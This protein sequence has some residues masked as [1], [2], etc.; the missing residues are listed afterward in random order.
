MNTP[1]LEAWAR[2]WREVA[3]A[4][5]PRPVYQ[6]LAT[7]YAQPHRHYHNLGHIAACLAEFNAARSLALQPLALE[8]AIWFHDAVYDPHAPDNEECSAALAARRL[9]EAGGV[10]ELRE[11]VAVLVLATKAH[12]GALHVDAPLLVDVDLSILG[13]T[14]E[15]FA[16]YER[17]IRAEYAWVPE[18]TFA[19]KRAELLE[20][21]LDRPHLYWTE[22]FRSKYERPARANLEG[23]IRKLRSG[24]ASSER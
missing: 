9:S 16:Q 13:R 21:F 17:Q 18:A 22:P 10:R 23:S 12:D 11:A 2:L 19:A 7:L 20:R 4:A 24:K 14:A 15:E 1:T 3:P 5:D 6:E 8:L